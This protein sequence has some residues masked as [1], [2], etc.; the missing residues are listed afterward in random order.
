MKKIGMTYTRIIALG[1]LIIICAGAFL[2]CLPFSSR[3]GQW[4]PVIDSLFTATS[5]TCVTGLTVVDTQ[6]HWS[7]FGQIV[8]LLLIQTGGLGFM[9]VITMFSIFMRKKIGLH[10]R[11]LLMQSAGTIRI[12][13]IIRLIRRVLYGTLIIEGIGTVLL[14]TRFCPRFGPVKGIWY[15]IF[16]SVSAFCNAGFDILGPESGGSFVGYSNDPVILITLMLL[17]V[18]GGIG[19]IAWND[20]LRC[21]FKFR[22]Y[23]LHTKIVILA[24]SILIISGSVF[25]FIT[26]NNRSL[27]GMGIGEKILNSFFLS[28]SPRTAGF[29]SVNQASLSESGSIITMLLMFI[30]GSPGSTAGG[31]KTTTFV[32]LVLSTLACARNLSSTSILRKKINSDTVRQASAII[33]TYISAVIAGSTVICAIENLPL[34]EVLFEVISAIATVGLSMGIT[35]DLGTASRIIIIMLMYAGRIGGLTLVV[36][37]AQK[38]EKIPLERPEEKILIG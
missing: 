23:E 26:E 29:A 6:T 16:H 27:A 3:S 22:M 2:L 37:L 20:I 31:I 4:T 5:A 8:I 36:A 7:L 28:V 33:F 14:T 17:I 24:T 30:G 1:F 11:R 34:K 15:S 12:S 19:F 13:G 10:E 32:V 35:P 25:L 38:R 18:I 9:T 21:K